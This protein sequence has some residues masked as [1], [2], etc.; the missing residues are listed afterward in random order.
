MRGFLLPVFSVSIHDSPSTNRQSLSAEVIGK[1][2]HV[3]NVMGCRFD[4][5]SKGAYT[6]CNCLN[7]ELPV[8]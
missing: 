4:W 5:L 3:A 1:L 7:N 2:Q 6:H 8:E